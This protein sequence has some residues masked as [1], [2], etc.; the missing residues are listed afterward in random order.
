MSD[1][2]AAWV[3]AI[4]LPLDDVEFY[5][6]EQEDGTPG[7]G[8]FLDVEQCPLWA[9][10]WLAQVAGVRWHGP[11]TERLRSLI[12]TRPASRRC[13]MPALRA[14]IAETLT[15]PAGVEPTIRVIERDTSRWHF[16]VV[17]RASETGDPESTRRAIESQTP[18]G[19]YFTHV[20]SDAP[21]IIEGTR[22]V[23]AATGTIDGATV[24][25]IT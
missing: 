4:T 8:R 1:L 10:P 23:D 7:Y 22:T 3:D 25:G 14:A 17:T 9:L 20:V 24:G 2:H 6:R 13:T 19:H 15:V 11:P 16:T 5:A 12:R 21:L 18:I